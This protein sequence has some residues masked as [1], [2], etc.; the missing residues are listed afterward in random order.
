VHGS[1][2]SDGATIEKKNS[3]SCEI[4]ALRENVVDRPES[5]DS[6]SAKIYMFL[7]HEERRTVRGIFLHPH[8]Q[9]APKQDIKIFLRH[10]T[11]TLVPSLTVQISD[12]V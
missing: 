3:A 11:T 12:I 5:Y 9:L 6:F 8:T 4:V 2:G 10:K 1:W 7:A